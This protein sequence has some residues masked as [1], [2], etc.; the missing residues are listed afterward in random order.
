MRKWAPGIALFAV[1]VVLDQA[2]KIWVE[3]TIPLYQGFSV[4]GD[5]FRI[6]FVRNP[7]GAFS[8]KFGGNTFYIIVASLASLFV[9]AYLIK[10]GNSNVAIRYSLFTIL[11]GAV[12]N[13]IDR[14]R[15]GE[16]IDWL[17]FGFGG[18]RWPTFNI[19]D[20]AIVVGLVILIIAGV[21]DDGK[22]IDDRSPEGA[23]PDETGQV[24]GDHGPRPQPEPDTTAH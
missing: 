11:S 4:I 15:V 9:V 13:L 7:G 22:K 19:A 18:T 10:A 8:T 24:S 20:A 12:G 3:R 5:F 14:F 23:D 17:D 16:V 1:L 21:E 2:T 6:T